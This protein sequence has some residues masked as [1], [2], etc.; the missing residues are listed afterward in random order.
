MFGNRKHGDSIEFSLLS[1]R[2]SSFGT[3]AE[4]G[5]K[6]I[7]FHMLTAIQLLYPRVGRT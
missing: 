5:L 3:G 6:Y 1:L 4:S 2:L 7:V